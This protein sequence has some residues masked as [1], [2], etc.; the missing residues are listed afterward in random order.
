MLLTNKLLLT[1]KIA[2]VSGADNAKGIGYGIA[3][4][5]V[6]YGARVAMLG[7]GQENLTELAAC[8]GKA[9]EGGPAAIGLHTD[10]TNPDDVRASLAQVVRVL[11][12]PT[13]IVA[14]AGIVASRTVASIAGGELMR[15][16]EVNVGGS[17]NLVQAA[18]PYLAP[19][20]SII[21]MG[22][23][24]AQQGGGLRGGPHYAASKGAVLSLT[25]AMARDLGPQGIRANT[26]HPGIVH[27]PMTA[28]GTP[29]LEAEQVKGIPL[30][31]LGEP[32]DIAGVAVFFASDLSQYITGVDLGVNGGLYIG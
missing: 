10:V 12:N 15:M 31:R 21:S 28:D 26:I 17:L 30:G 6:K 11:G 13:T 32:A 2:I 19:G 14:N 8:L 22:S 3:S 18:L 29:E 24:A 7:L 27:S 16:L 5:F 4:A 25:R 23:I 9:S 1:N 20:S